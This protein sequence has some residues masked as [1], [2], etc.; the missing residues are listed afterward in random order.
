MKRALSLY[1]LQEIIAYLTTS[2]RQQ[3]FCLRSRLALWQW[4]LA[5]AKKF[6]P[7]PCQI[8][9]YFLQMVLFLALTPL[10]FSEEGMWTF[11]KLPLETIQKQYGVQL[12]PAFLS[13]IQRASLRLS[14]GGSGSFV[15]SNGLL[16]TNHHVGRKAIYDLSTQENNLVHNGFLAK[17]LSQELKCPALYVDQL[18]SIHDVTDQVNL[19]ESE[20]LSPSEREQAR[21][22]RIALLVKKAQEETSLQPEMVSLYGGAKYHLYLYKRYSDVRLVMSPEEEVAFF[23]GDAENFEYPRYNLDISFFRVYD[24]D[25]PLQV[26]DYLKWSHEGPRLDEPLFVAGNP[27]KTSRLYTSAHLQFVKDIETPLILKFLEERRER[28][29]QFASTGKEEMR[30]ASC[31]LFSCENALK[32]RRT[33]SHDLNTGS[34]IAD[35]TAREKLLNQDPFNKLS[36]ALEKAENYYPEYMV[37]EGICSNYSKLYSYAKLLIRYEQERLKPN[38]ERLPEFQDAELK[39]LQLKLGSEEPVYKS[40]EQVQLLQTLGFALSSS[41][42]KNPLAQKIGSE[43][44]LEQQIKMWL[45][46]TK[47]DDPAYRADL[48]DHPE[49]IATTED[50]FFDLVR[51]LDP[52][53]RLLRKQRED[54]LDSVMH[55]SYETINQQLFTLYGESVYPDAT[56]TLRLS[57]GSM[58]GYQDKGAY[59]KP[60]TTMEGLYALGKEHD[61]KGSYTIPE[62]W[63]AKKEVLNQTTPFNFVTTND[64]IGGNSGSPVINQ[65]GEF[66]GIIFD[67]N[68][69]SIIWSYGFDS[70]QGRATS[71]HSAGIL[72]ALKTIYQADGLIREIQGQIPYTPEVVKE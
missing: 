31:G 6:M 54:E 51:A 9:N 32:V 69:Q 19:Q 24:Q 68:I 49:K 38:T 25:K 23:G 70:R 22:K 40:L 10:L 12:E 26:T 18:I 16:I 67:G 41:P 59:V 28:F 63:L 7:P 17:E 57:V 64:I 3:I 15:S 72:E 62:R 30:I 14:A 52:R 65:K 58:L 50:P 48:F 39:T 53:A 42:D 60:I 4:S 37:L 71:V 27:G 20:N 36:A 8:C 46:K 34:L 47:L 61:Y 11:N 55:D 56:F 66:V 21:K 35:K 44:P 33:L 2:A 29:A 43:I 5:P 1:H 45:Q 13:S